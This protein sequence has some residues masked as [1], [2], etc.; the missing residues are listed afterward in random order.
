MSTENKVLLLQIEK[1]SVE[2]TDSVDPP[3]S[4]AAEAWSSCQKYLVLNQNT[5]LIKREWQLFSEIVQRAAIL[6]TAQEEVIL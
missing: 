2:F 5:E 6:R 1:P 4:L 3:Q